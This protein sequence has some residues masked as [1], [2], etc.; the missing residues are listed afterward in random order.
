[1]PEGIGKLRSLKEIDMRECSRLRKVPKSI[2][3]LKTLKHVTC[4]EKIEQQWIFIKK[5]AIP[6]LVVEVVEEHFTLD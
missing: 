6:D 4:D 2:Q 3:G 1:L 5:F